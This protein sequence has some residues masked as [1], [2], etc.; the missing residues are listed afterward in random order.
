LNCGALGRTSRSVLPS[1]SYT[2]GG[3]ESGNATASFDDI[4]TVMGGVGTGYIRYSLAGWMGCP[5][6]LAID[7]GYGFS[8]NSVAIRRTRS[9]RP[10]G[11]LVPPPCAALFYALTVILR[12]FTVSLAAPELS[13]NGAAKLGEP[14]IAHFWLRLPDWASPLFRVQLRRPH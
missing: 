7:N 6:D 9:P 2:S 10:R 3:A 14:R 8:I 11:L 13:N 4:L 12:C 1:G 5:T